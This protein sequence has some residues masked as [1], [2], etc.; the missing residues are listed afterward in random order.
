M[1]TKRL[2]FYVHVSSHLKAALKLIEKLKTSERYEPI[3]YLNYGGG[4]NLRKEVTLCKQLSIPFITDSVGAAD[5]DS[6]KG[7]EADDYLETPYYT[8]KRGSNTRSIKERVKGFVIKS[9]PVFVYWYYSRKRISEFMEFLSTND[10]DAVILPEDPYDDTAFMVKAARNLQRP[11][12][13]I[14]FAKS[15]HDDIPKV[16]MTWLSKLFCSVFPKWKM[17]FKG[18]EYMPAKLSTVI[19]TELMQIAPV[20]PFSRMG[21]RSQVMLVENEDD[22]IYYKENGIPEKKM[23]KTGAVYQDVFVEILAAKS[24]FKTNLCAKYKIVDRRPVILCNLFPIATPVDQ[25]YV[26]YDYSSVRE[27]IS[28]WLDPLLAAKNFQVWINHH[29]RTTIE[30]VKYL[31]K[32]DLKVIY[33]PIEDVLPLCDLYVTGASSTNR[34][35]LTLAKPIVCYTEE[36]VYTD[37]DK[38]KSATV[39]NTK[40][41]YL[42]AI[43]KVTE[44]EAHFKYITA[45][46]KEDAKN[47]GPIDGT[48]YE[49]ILSTFDSLLKVK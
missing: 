9:L 27:A 22:L 16:K 10:I 39:P 11:S 46:A 19:V 32:L 24:D 43:K 5:P 41:E 13:L 45:C 14:P 17:S 3:V 37:L 30:Y 8:P 47:F 40:P 28:F 2:L 15:N 1:V 29:P 21:G 49:R 7:L 18:V 23:I 4:W 26:G 44:D 48:S 42:A 35:A 33:E 20:Q 34:M 12:V 6:K 31:E 38:F 25:V 36:F